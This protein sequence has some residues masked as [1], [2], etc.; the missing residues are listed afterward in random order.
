METSKIGGN[1]QDL[2]L[3]KARKQDISLT[4]FLVNGVQLK[5]AVKSFDNFTVLLDD[6]G[7]LQLIYKHAIST[8]IPHSNIK[9]TD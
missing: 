3:N 8:I 2:F 1:L 9:L 4:V 7:K 5:G 6:N